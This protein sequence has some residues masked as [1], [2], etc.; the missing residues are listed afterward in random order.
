MLSH[1][2]SR[3][4]HAG[5]RRIA[6]YVAMG[7]FVLWAGAG[8]GMLFGLARAGCASDRSLAAAAEPIPAGWR[9]EHWLPADHALTPILAERLMRQGARRGREESIHVDER[10]VALAAGLERAGW[11]VVVERAGV[12]PSPEPRLVIFSPAGA[13]VWSGGYRSD[14]VNTAG[15]A[16]LDDLTL[17]QVAQGRRLPAFVLIG[18]GLP[19]VGESASSGQ[20]STDL[21]I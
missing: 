12:N 2:Q 11:K 10:A 6:A 4:V 8:V 3:P 17:A 1:D 16:I 15:A 19:V 9:M 21:S 18:C 7:T 5:R 13:R 20:P 14:E